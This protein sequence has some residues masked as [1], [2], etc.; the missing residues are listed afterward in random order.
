[1]ASR[2]PRKN[3]LAKHPAGRVCGPGPQYQGRQVCFSGS[4]FCYKQ[5]SQRMCNGLQGKHKWGLLYFFSNSRGD[6]LSTPV[7]SNLARRKLTGHLP[8][9]TSAAGDSH[10]TAQE[11]KFKFMLQVRRWRGKEC[12]L[13]TGQFFWILALGKPGQCLFPVPRSPPGPW[14][15]LSQY[16]LNEPMLCLPHTYRNTINK[17]TLLESF[18]IL[19]IV[20]IL[21][22]KGGYAPRLGTIEAVT[23]Q[24]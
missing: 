2:N 19:H 9:D 15:A 22:G 7:Y 11:G 6:L 12:D 3:L 21:H 4:L 13:P 8:P 23:D 5:F 18:T 10:Q 20:Q 24:L 16:L 14:E 1:M 17:G